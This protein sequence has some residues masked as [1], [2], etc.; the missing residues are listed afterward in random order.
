MSITKRHCP[1]CGKTAKVFE[2]YG[3]AKRPDAKCP[4][5]GSLERHRF[6]FIYLRKQ[7]NF[8]HKD[9]KILHIAPERCLK[10]IFS[11]VKTYIPGDLYK[12]NVEK[13]NICRIDYPDNSFDFIYCSHVLEHV[14]DDRKAMGE[15]C[16]VLKPKCYAMINAPIAKKLDKTFDDPSI[17][18][19]KE[20]LEAF[21][22]SDHV[23][24][25][26]RDYRDRLEAAGF[27]VF[28]YAPDDKLNPDQIERYGLNNIIEENLFFCI[29]KAP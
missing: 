3:L 17:T 4:H 21:G 28:C 9:W 12:K 25:Y 22:Q 1:I 11:S 29:K 6:D 24:R 5:C 16:R 20:R 7:P 19:E 14:L 26:G 18:D 13:I 27:H 15:L 23:R 10:N 8:L 2:S